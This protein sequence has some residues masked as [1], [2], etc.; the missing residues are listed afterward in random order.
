M[1]PITDRLPLDE[2]G[3]WTKDVSAVRAAKT[4]DAVGTTRLLI[5]TG[6]TLTVRAD[7]QVW[8]ET[9][10][11]ERVFPEQVLVL[12]GFGVPVP[13]YTD[14]LLVLRAWRDHG[15]G[16]GVDKA[17]TVATTFAPCRA[18]VTSDESLLPMLAHD[19]KRSV[20]RLAHTFLTDPAFGGTA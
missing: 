20:A 7:R 11:G 16:V 14:S 18:L 12:V 3:Q 19:P 6:D 9:A 4:V 10:S 8:V 5:E 13:E 17:L 1:F 15:E 2:Q